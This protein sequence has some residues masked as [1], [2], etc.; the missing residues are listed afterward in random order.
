M[1][2]AVL[3]LHMVNSQGCAMRACGRVFLP[4]AVAH[5]TL[6]D[7]P[8][9]LPLVNIQLQAIRD[10]GTNQ[11]GILSCGMGVKALVL[12]VGGSERSAVVAGVR[13]MPCNTI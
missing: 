10:R 9:A 6:W 12:I 4:G 1:F 3:A 5:C 8:F 2:V 13:L 11:S 7:F